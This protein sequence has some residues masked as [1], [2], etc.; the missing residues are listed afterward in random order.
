VKSKDWRLNM[1]PYVTKAILKQ[2]LS[3][4]LKYQDHRQCQLLDKAAH[5]PNR[6]PTINSDWEPIHYAVDML[7]HVIEE[8]VE[9][10]RLI[11]ARKWWANSQAVSDNTN[12]L[13]S[14]TD[15]RAELVEELID[16]FIQWLNVCIYLS[17]GPNELANTYL[18]KMTFKNNPNSDQCTLGDRS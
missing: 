8:C 9:A 11:K 15:K 5:Q 10:K 13:I 16:I 18:R 1:E 14:D 4:L 17:V 6:G 12:D 2:A 7:N 3:E